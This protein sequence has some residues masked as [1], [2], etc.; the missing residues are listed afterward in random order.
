MPGSALLV[1]QHPPVAQPQG[2][3]GHDRNQEAQQGLPQV[4]GAA[5]GILNA[6]ASDLHSECLTVVC[7]ELGK[8]GEQGEQQ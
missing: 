1:D 8:E 3:P 5:I 6:Y 2:K 7:P 4:D